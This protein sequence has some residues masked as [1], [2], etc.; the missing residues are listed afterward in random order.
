MP[1]ATTRPAWMNA[2]TSQTESASARS[3]VA[4][5]MVREPRSRSSRAAPERAPL[6]GVDAGSWFVEEQELGVVQQGAGH[7]EAP[8]HTPESDETGSVSHGIRGQRRRGVRIERWRKRAPLTPK[9]R[10]ASTQ[11]L[12]ERS[13]VGRWCSPGRRCRA[14]RARLARASGRRPGV[15]LRVA[16]PWRRGGR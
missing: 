3:L 8:A 11:G 7:L 12:D 9:S 1:L 2:T 10:P 15:H 4:R 5:R 14:G 6:F 16:F 13:S